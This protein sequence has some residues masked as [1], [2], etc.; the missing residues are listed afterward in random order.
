MAGQTSPLASSHTTSKKEINYPHYDVKKP[1]IQHQFDLLN[2]PH[3]IFEGNTYKYVLTG[4]DV[5]SGYKVPRPLRTKK[6]SEVAVVLEAIY[7]MRSV[8]EYLAVFQ[9]DNGSEFKNEVTNLLEKHNVDIRR[10]TRKYKQTHTDFVEAFNKKLAKLL[11]KLMDVQELQNPEKVSAIWVKTV[12][13]MNNTVLSVIGMKLKDVIKLDTV[14]LDK[15]YP[16][17]TVLPK[18]G[19]YSNFINLV[20]N[21]ETRKDGQQTLSGVKIHT[22]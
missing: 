3:N 8:F 16:Q 21:M 12:N 20:N 9:C 19:L 7:K 17:E 13:K 15:T 1:N 4:I 5:A 6:S 10:A 2:M 18:D 14:P 11:F 22:N